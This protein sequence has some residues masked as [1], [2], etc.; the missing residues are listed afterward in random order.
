MEKNFKDK[1]EYISLAEAAEN[2]PYSQEYLSLRARQGKLKAIKL[3]RNWATKKEWLEEY[4]LKAQNYREELNQKIKEKELKRG[5]LEVE[6]IKEGPKEKIP[7]LEKRIEP[8]I[9]D[10][11]KES[12]LRFGVVIG[13]AFL[14]LTSSIALGKGGFPGA[15]KDVK[16]VFSD[17]AERS[18]FVFN[19]IAKE[20]NKGGAEVSLILNQSLS[21][22]EELSSIYPTTVWQETGHVFASYF[23]WLKD[24]LGSVFVAK[25]K[26]VAWEKDVNKSI[27]TDSKI[28]SLTDLVTQ[29][30]LDKEEIASLKEQITGLKQQGVTTK[31]IITEVQQVTQILPKEVIEKRVTLVDSAIA[32]EMDM[33]RQDLE[34]LKEWEQ[35]IINLQE[36]TEKLKSSPAQVV[37]TSAPI[38][39]EQQGVQVGGLGMFDSL[40]VSGASSLKDL[41]VGGNTTL[42]NDSSDFLTINATSNFLSSMS[43]GPNNELTVDTSGNLVTS[44][45]ITITGLSTLGTIS[46]ATWNGDIIDSQ[47]GGTGKDSSSWTGIVRVDSGVFSTTTVAG[48]S[49]DVTDVGDCTGGACFDGTSDGGTYLDFYDAQGRT[50]I[51]GG[52]TAA[53]VTLTLPTTT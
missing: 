51:I 5:V 44:G 41:G 35:D 3:G 4:L 48:G 32:E 38:Y 31:Q 12:G 36:I 29:N 1:K 17:V 43:V 50:R 24:K 40:A 10:P 42:G 30:E 23:G 47:Y 2:F 9:I 46:S 19:S 15:L 25:P 14:V 8:P 53:E 20:I 28:N 37:H 27:I 52:D 7:E 13:L 34:D 49:G 45:N 26:T 39:I 6:K 18:S 16:I 22:V 11:V 33:L 21:P